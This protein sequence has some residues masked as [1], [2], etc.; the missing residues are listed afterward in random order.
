[1]PNHQILSMH[2]ENFLSFGEVDFDFEATGPVL[3]EGENGS[4][5]SA[6][7][8]AL[9]WCLWG[10]TL[11]GY[12][13]D[14]VVNRKVGEGCVVT[15]RLRS[16][17]SEWGVT[18]TRRHKKLR[19][20][21]LMDR[22]VPAG[23]KEAQLEIERRLGCTERTFM[24]SV[25]F[26]QDP[27]YRFSQLGDADQKKVLDEV[28]GVERFARAC[29]AARAK[30]SEVQAGLAVTQRGLQKAAEAAADAQSEAIDLKTKDADFAASQRT[31]VEAERDKLRSAKKWIKSNDKVD[32][33][34]LKERLDAAQHAVSLYDRKL[35]KAATAAGSAAGALALAAG[36]RDEVA[37]RLGEWDET[38]CPTCGQKFDAKMR[39]KAADILRAELAKLQEEHDAVVVTN[40]GAATALATAKTKLK[41][42]RATSDEAQ[43]AYNEGVG[44]AADSASLRRRASEHEARIAEIEAEVSPYWAL[45]EKALSRH[46]KHAA[47]VDRLTEEA[48]AMDAQHR[49]AQFWVKAYGNAGLRSLLIDSS[50]PV[51]NAEAE[52]VSQML[53]GGSIRIE[54]SATTEQKSGKVVDR[55]EVKV[56][57]EHGAGDYAGNSSGE[58]AKVDLCVGLALQRLVASRSSASFN[59][60]FF[61][62][63]FDHLDS[64]AHE[65]VI[66]V[67]TGL[68][69]DSVIVVSHDD[70]LKAWFP[71]TLQMVKSGGFSSVEA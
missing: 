15:V 8:D 27:A 67:L 38:V 39:T 51:L 21:L 31:K 5:K 3:V 34:A 55:F 14:E 1:M 64:A 23:E 54:F 20:A 59:V 68:D 49:S 62:E 29:A 48:K 42:A 26:G 46:A 32:V 71:A 53:T 40:D 33:D 57:N 9:C 44:L 10:I 22:F 7:I 58:R 65:R 50:L 70:D 17:G 6:M 25:V 45:A 24:S 16:G 47:D 13:H 19:N 12:E 37:R 41:E 66:N 4:G 36:R 63:V 35:A 43:K 69:K 11:R 2:A 52:R 60:A 56:D 28:L 18:R 61:D 30:A